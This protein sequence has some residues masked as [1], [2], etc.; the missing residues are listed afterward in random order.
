MNSSDGSRDRREPCQPAITRAGNGMRPR[1]P[2]GVR[3]IFLFVPHT[4]ATFINVLI[5]MK[6]S[7]GSYELDKDW[8]PWDH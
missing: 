2:I 3:T 4:D 6:F 5:Q 7:V 1:A 8:E